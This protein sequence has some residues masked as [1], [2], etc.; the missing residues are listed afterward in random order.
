MA[1]VTVMILAVVEVTFSFENAVVNSQVLGNMNR[2]WR[3]A[4]LTVGI[5]IAVFGVRL[6]LPLLLVSL[7]TDLSLKGVLDQA[8]H[9]P[10]A[11]RA[12]LD[13][14]RPIIAAFGGV[15]L[16]MVG[17]RFFGEK[18]DVRW[19][20]SVE[21]PLAEF[22]Q[23]WRITLTGAGLAIL[24]LH[25]ILAPDQSR[26]TWAAIAGALTFVAIKL[27][28][29]A[30]TRH[31]PSGKQGRGFSQFIYLEILDASF[32]FDS[33]IA[34]FTIT[35]DVILITAGLGIGALYVRSM[36]IHLLNR[37]TLQRYRY[38]VH[39]AHYAIL[40]LAAVLLVSVRWHLPE[41]VSGL[42]GVVFILAAVQSSHRYQP[43]TAD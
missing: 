2:F 19:L 33:V 36:T 23:P 18:R 25:F 37:G 31:R 34:A 43:S 16:L 35:K 30:L 32:S 20:D 28:G 15:F 22:N 7:T 39:G 12:A 42:L 1:L 14:A 21:A 24:V 26:V 8:L 9:N 6:L 3:I 29:T 40:A 10:D 27:L 41:I 17:L 4:F 38:L 11:Y 13:E 5:A